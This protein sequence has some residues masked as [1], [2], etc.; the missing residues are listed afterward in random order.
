MVNC[1]GKEIRA[2]AKVVSDFDEEM[3]KLIHGSKSNT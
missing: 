1:S 3:K 2:I